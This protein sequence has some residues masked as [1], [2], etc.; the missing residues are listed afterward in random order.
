MPRLYPSTERSVS[1]AEQ[2]SI[3]INNNSSKELTI[4]SNPS[5]GMGMGD[6]LF[7]P[8]EMQTVLFSNSGTYVFTIKEFPT[9]KLTVIVKNS[10][11]N[12]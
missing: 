4:S 12:D 1:L 10:G 11:D 8:G 6:M 2:Q 9:Q 3:M 7:H 5:V